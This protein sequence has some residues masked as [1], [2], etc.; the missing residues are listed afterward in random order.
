VSDF[1]A[2]LC[3]HVP[4]QGQQLVRYYGAF[5]NARRVPA[6]TPASPSAQ[7]ANLQLGRLDDSDSGEEFA[8]FDD[9]GIGPDATG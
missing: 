4:D 2:A 8:G 3:A 1:L 7:P 6:Q 9:A 5:S